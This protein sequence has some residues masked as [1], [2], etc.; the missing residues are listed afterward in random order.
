MQ[1]ARELLGDESKRAGISSG[2]IKNQ[3]TSLGPIGMV[4]GGSLFKSTIIKSY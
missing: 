2:V 1:A 4:I 3:K